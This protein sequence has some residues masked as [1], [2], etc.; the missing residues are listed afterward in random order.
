MCSYNLEPRCFGLCEG[1]G[2]GSLLRSVSCFNQ[3]EEQAGFKCHF[4]SR[5]VERG[6]SC[7]FFFFF[8]AVRLER[9]VF[10]VF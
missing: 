9:K 6:E 10:H 4:S 5:F 8:E 7:I 1:A 2:D 3:F